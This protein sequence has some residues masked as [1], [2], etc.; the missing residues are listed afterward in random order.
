MWTK[1]A[2]N[3]GSNWKG[4]I[5]NCLGD[6]LTAGDV[7]GNGTMGTPWTSYIPALTGIATCRNY[8]Q[9]GTKLS[10]TDAA[11]FV[12]R[13]TSMNSTADIISVW[14]GTN[15]F[16]F[17]AAL[18]AMGDT[19]NVTF[20]GALDVLIKGLYAK[21]PN[22]ELFFIT[23]PKINKPAL[24]ETYTP[25][26]AGK[27][28]KDYRDAIIAMCDKYSVPVLDLFSDSSMSCYLDTGTYRPDN[29]HF[30][31]AGYQRISHKIAN[32]INTL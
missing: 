10:T 3:S 22:A 20:Y 14:G 30:T 32:F 17:G 12:N 7:V 13:Y 19:S 6:S 16:C 1:P 5:M 4:K 23:P 21:Y 11:A 26:S 15:D 29:L 28:L 9:N 27:V 24:G 31:V 18:G 25:N 8:G 2:N